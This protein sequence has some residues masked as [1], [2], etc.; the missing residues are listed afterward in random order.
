[1]EESPAT[2]STRSVT[3]RHNLRHYPSHANA[4]PTFWRHDFTQKVIGCRSTLLC[5]CISHPTPASLTFGPF[6]LRHRQTTPV[7]FFFFQLQHIWR[8]FSQSGTS[9]RP[10]GPLGNRILFIQLTLLPFSLLW[11]ENGAHLHLWGLFLRPT[12]IRSTSTSLRQPNLHPIRLLP[13]SVMLLLA[14]HIH[15]DPGFLI[16]EPLIIFP[17]IKTFFLPLPLLLLY[18]HLL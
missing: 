15:L 8:S 5:P 18:P 3:R 17:I 2:N 1:M 12:N 6:S 10:C 7:L 4:W 13:R 11:P 16:M 9:K 14:F